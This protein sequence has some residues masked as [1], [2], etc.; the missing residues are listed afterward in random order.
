M[1]ATFSEQSALGLTEDMQVRSDGA[2]LATRTKWPALGADEQAVWGLC[3]GSGKEPYRVCVDKSELAYR[4]SCPSKKFPCKHTMGLL[5]LFAKDQSQFASLPAPGWVTEWLA[6]RQKRAAK[7]D[8]Q[9]AAVEATPVDTEAQRKRAQA[10]A[11][12]VDEGLAELRLWL[13]D[14]MRHG[15]VNPQVKSYA[16]WDRMAARLVDAQAGSIARRLRQIAGIPMQGQPDW[17]ARLLDEISRIYLLAESYPR[18]ATLPPALQ[19]DVRTAIGWSHKREEL[20]GLPALRDQWQVVGQIIE[21]DELLASRRV[22]MVGER[23]G[24]SA[25]LLDFA[26]R[27][28]FEENYLNG[29]RYDAELIYY[30]SAYPQRALVKQTHR[31][32]SPNAQPASLPAFANIEAMLAHYANALGCNPWVERVP[33]RLDRATLARHDQ[34]WAIYDAEARTLPIKQPGKNVTHLW[35]FLAQTGGHPR[36]MMGEWDG[37]AAILLD[38]GA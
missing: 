1:I 6:G 3:Q 22:W 13:T 37:Y 16:Y 21:A 38:V 14:L 31:I 24:Q 11:N 20:L 18:I 30:P 32:T 27:P 5:L 7:E 33:F 23:S 28:S 25:L 15:F 10:R 4:C 9:D 29:Q 17:A 35:N 19:E 2:K 36:T 8:A 12:K 26:R 34:G